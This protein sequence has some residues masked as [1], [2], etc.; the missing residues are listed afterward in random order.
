MYGYL[1][2]WA[3]KSMTQRVGNVELG[4]VYYGL[5]RLIPTYLRVELTPRKSGEPT[6]DTPETT[7]SSK[8]VQYH[9]G[10]PNF[11]TKSSR[12]LTKRTYL[13]SRK[14]ICWCIT[15]ISTIGGGCVQDGPTRSTSCVGSDVSSSW[16]TSNVPLVAWIVDKRLRTFWWGFRP[17]PDKP[18]RGNTSP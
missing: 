8:T 11:R 13:T 3:R 17:Y 6:G 16:T 9:Y 2:H 5:V 1:T 4:D 7:T 10:S 18:S 15:D 14:R 12:T